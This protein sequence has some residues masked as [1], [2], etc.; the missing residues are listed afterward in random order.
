MGISKNAAFGREGERPVIGNKVS[1]AKFSL[2]KQFGP[3]V[4]HLCSCD[5][6]ALL[7]HGPDLDFKR[8]TSQIRLT[9]WY[10]LQVGGL[11]RGKP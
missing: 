6:T 11:V 3:Q 9:Y 10:H 2:L 4:G 5:L 1:K 8:G 7:H